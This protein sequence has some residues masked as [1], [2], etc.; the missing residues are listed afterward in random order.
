MPQGS[1]SDTIPA[2][3]AEVFVLLHDYVRRLQWDTLL[4][5]AR[6]C[7]GWTAAQLHATSV[8]TGRR[9]LGR[10]ALKTEYVSFCPPRVAA[11]KMVNRPPFFETFAA[12]IRHRDLGDGSSKIEYKYNFTARPS[13]LQWLLHPLMAAVFRWE[14]RKRLA[15]LRRW[16]EFQQTASTAIV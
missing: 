11:V 6:L 1:V 7:D 10:I 12:T 9:R 5:D 16:F 3:S 2:P 15:A 14:T 8:C 13:W 4:A